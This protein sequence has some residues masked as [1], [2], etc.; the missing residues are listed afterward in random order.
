MIDYVKD[1]QPAELKGEKA[2][3]LDD[4]ENYPDFT[5]I[6]GTNNR[7]FTKLYDKRDDFNF[8][9]VNFLFLSSCSYGVYI[10]QLI[11]Y[12]RCCTHYDDF[13]YHHK[14][15]VDR[16]L[17]QGYKVNQLRNSFQAFYG[18]YPDLVTKNQKPFSEMLRLLYYT[19]DL[20]CEG[21]V[22]F[23]NH[24]VCVFSASGMFSTLEGY[25][26]YIGGIP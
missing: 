17:C 15:P 4:Q 6:I 7:L 12:A 2:N 26:E 25:H 24:P 3:R 9:I 21:F 11:S 14:L 5:F 22:D 18:R 23:H 1:I 10:S 16:L 13:A 8:Y 20:C 19:V